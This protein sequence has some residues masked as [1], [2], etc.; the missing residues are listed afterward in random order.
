M[1]SKQELTGKYHHYK[2]NEYEVIGIG[3]HT[4]TEERL[5]VYRALYAPYELW[6]R[7]FAMF[8]ETVT[9]DGKDIQ[10]F[11]KLQG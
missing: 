3:K 8:F 5:V 9:I 11:E 6:I 1:S 4:E 10:R 2:G 7:P